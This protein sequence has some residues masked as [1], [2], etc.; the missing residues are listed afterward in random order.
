V[1]RLLEEGRPGARAFPKRPYG[2]VLFADTPQAT[3]ERA[4]DLRR[5]GFRA[6][7]FG[8]GPMGPDEAL[9]VALVRAAREGLGAGPELMVDAGVAWGEDDETAYRRAV[10][11]EPF[12]LTWLEEP[13]GLGVDV[14][15]AVLK[16]FLKEVEIRVAGKTLYR[17]PAID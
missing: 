1:W 4:A 3:G 17:T 13:S 6:A 9:D 7:K 2:S 8:W 5:R 14:D 11:F 12:G 16:E 10:A 15:R